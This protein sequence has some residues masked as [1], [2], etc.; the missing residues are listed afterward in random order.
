MPA[1]YITEALFVPDVD[2]SAVNVTISGN[3]AAQGLGVSVTIY[4]G[5]QLIS[6]QARLFHPL[7]RLTSWSCILNVEAVSKKCIGHSGALLVVHSQQRP[8]GKVV[9]QITSALE[10]GEWARESH[11]LPAELFSLISI[12][13][14]LQSFNY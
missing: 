7:W 6:I 10:R 12:H 11:G 5:E 14:K 1:A 3:D 9:Y 8:K 13:A 4:Q 2:N